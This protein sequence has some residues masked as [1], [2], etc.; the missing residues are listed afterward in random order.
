MEDASDRE[1]CNF[2]YVSKHWQKHVDAH[3]GRHL[4]LDAYTASSKAGTYLHDGRRAP[5]ISDVHRYHFLAPVAGPCEVPALARAVLAHTRVLDLRRISRLS[6]LVAILPLPKLETLRVYPHSASPWIHHPLTPLSWKCLY[7]GGRYGAALPAPEMPAA[8]R[9]VVFFS[10]DEREIQ[11]EIYQTPGIFPGV[12]ELVVHFYPVSPWLLFPQ[13]LMTYGLHRLGPR[14][15][16]F[17]FT[18]DGPTSRPNQYQPLP[19]ARLAELVSLLPEDVRVTVVGFE[20]FTRHPNYDSAVVAQD[21]E[22]HSELRRVVFVDVCTFQEQIGAATWALYSEKPPEVPV[23]E[24]VLT[25]P[26]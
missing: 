6:P 12:E 20:V 16:T 23:H 22:L 18:D 24:R 4:V 17:I 3:L 9:L 26:W 15:A 25:N 13:L 10:P 1:L 11:C 5:L 8:R 2:R 19:A 7:D 21:F 14:T